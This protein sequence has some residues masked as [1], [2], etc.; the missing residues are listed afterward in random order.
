[1]ITRRGF[2]GLL[3]ALGLPLAS[4]EQREVVAKE[5]TINLSGGDFTIE[6]WYDPSGHIDDVRITHTDKHQHVIV[7]GTG[8][9]T[10]VA[11]TKSGDKYVNGVKQ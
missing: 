2:L 5:E 9:W 6:F 7:T 8:S 10:H 3:A 11:V 1:M 4:A